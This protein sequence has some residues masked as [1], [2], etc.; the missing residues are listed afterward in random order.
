MGT[1]S[2]IKYGTPKVKKNSHSQ[3][4]AYSP[5]EDIDSMV[6]FCSPKLQ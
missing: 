5:F 3:M 1:I 2:V 6:Q 4:A